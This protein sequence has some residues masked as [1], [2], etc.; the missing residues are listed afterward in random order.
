[1]RPIATD[2]DVTIDCELMTLDGEVVINVPLAIQYRDF[3]GMAEQVALWNLYVD[4]VNKL[5][6]IRHVPEGYAPVPLEF[7]RDAASDNMNRSVN[8]RQGV[9]DRAMNLTKE[10]MK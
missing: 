6:N 7:I 9:I 5:E 4:A 1:M 10:Q 3:N 8:W 2:V